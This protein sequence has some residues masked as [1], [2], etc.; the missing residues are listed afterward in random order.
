MCHCITLCVSIQGGIWHNICLLFLKP[1]FGIKDSFV[2][3]E[4]V[5]W[6]FPGQQ[7]PS[8]AA[9]NWG[10]LSLLEGRV[11]TG[12]ISCLFISCHDK[13]PSISTAP[14]GRH[15]I[16]VPVTDCKKEWWIEQQ[17][18]HPRVTI[19]HWA[20]ARL[21][22]KMGKDLERGESWGK[23]NEAWILKRTRLAQS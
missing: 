1:K 23:Q 4:Y 13:T 18:R 7:I 14:S 10:L 19:Y 11:L 2:E 20:S 3:S 17:W 5:A 9:Q 16:C 8:T 15:T 21:K 6:S 22:V 12:M